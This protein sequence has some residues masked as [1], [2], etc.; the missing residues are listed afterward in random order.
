M[1]ASLAAVALG[2]V[3]CLGVGAAAAQGPRPGAP[4]VAPSTVRPG[5]EIRL[6][7][8]TSLKATAVEA[9]LSALQANFTLLYRQMQDMQLEAQKLL[10][11]RKVLLEGAAR[12]ANVDVR[13]PTE[14]VLDTRGQRY[15]R[16]QR[17]AAA[18]GGP[19]PQR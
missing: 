12:R 18:P 17:P 8:T 15:V 4:P 10:D 7:E 5:D 16:V 13:D 9:R 3:V 6:D 14:W 2:G 19:A 1:R 11:E